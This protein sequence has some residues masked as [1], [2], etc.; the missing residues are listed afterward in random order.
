MAHDTAGTVDLGSM[1]PR[2][3]QTQGTAGKKNIFAI[4][5]PFQRFPEGPD[6]D[7]RG[8]QTSSRCIGH[9][10]YH[11]RNPHQAGALDID[12]TY[13]QQK[14]AKK[15]GEEEVDAQEMKKEL[16]RKKEKAVRQA[17]EKGR[18]LAFNQTLKSRRDKRNLHMLPTR[19]VKTVASRRRSQRYMGRET[20]QQKC[21]AQE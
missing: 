16:L 2:S 19:V 4:I 20:H 9:C 10:T 12:L 11:R 3:N 1:T 21:I 18:L 13:R 6:G 17:Y 8:P 7:Y 5:G 15:V 14:N